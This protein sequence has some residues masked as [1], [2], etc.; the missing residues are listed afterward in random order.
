MKVFNIGDSEVNV[1]K[2]ALEYYGGTYE[3]Q[4]SNEKDPQVRAAAEYEAS[5]IRTTHTLLKDMRLQEL[6]ERCLSYFWDRF[7]EEGI[8]NPDVEYLADEMG[9]DEYELRELFREAGY[10]E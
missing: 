4:V 3:L 2:D 5:H 7:S 9:I 1:I 8:D 10:E 6:C